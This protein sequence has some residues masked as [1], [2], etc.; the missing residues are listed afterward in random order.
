MLFAL[1]PL[2]DAVWGW[3]GGVRG[4]TDGVAA[5]RAGRSAG[6]RV[7]KLSSTARTAAVVLR[8]SALPPGALTSRWCAEPGAHEREHARGGQPARR[9]RGHWLPVWQRVVLLR[10]GHE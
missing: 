3:V 5:A 9:S 2:G 10:A 7:P 4:M 1:V 6:K 8:S